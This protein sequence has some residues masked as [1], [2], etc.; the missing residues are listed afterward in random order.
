MIAAMRERYS[1]AWVEEELGRGLMKFM[2]ALG[3]VVRSL[4]RVKPRGIVEEF[5][6]G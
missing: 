2:C 5:G 4:R 3:R 6:E 1:S